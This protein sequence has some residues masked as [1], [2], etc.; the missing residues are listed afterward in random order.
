MKLIPQEVNLL[1]EIPKYSYI[2]KPIKLVIEKGFWNIA[3][4][5]L[6]AKVQA[7]SI[8]H[9]KKIKKPNNSVYHYIM[10]NII[11]DLPMIDPNDSSL[12][13]WAKKNM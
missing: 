8:A 10:E 7:W 13:C 3:I 4:G 1:P 12:V 6:W 11:H 5:R 9:K 2:E